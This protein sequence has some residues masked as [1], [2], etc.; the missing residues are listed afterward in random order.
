MRKL[1]I[2]RFR[3]VKQNVNTHWLDMLGG[4]EMADNRSKDFIGKLGMD[5]IKKGLAPRQ[6]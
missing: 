3:K 5:I 4:I 6:Q 2:G 1:L